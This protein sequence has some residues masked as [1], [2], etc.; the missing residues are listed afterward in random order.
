MDEWIVLIRH[1]YSFIMNDYLHD[2]KKTPGGIVL[3]NIYNGE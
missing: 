1:I 2:P 3:I